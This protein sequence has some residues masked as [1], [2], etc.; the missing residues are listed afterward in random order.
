MPG[1]N[2]APLLVLSLSPLS[3]VAA[4]APAAAAATT[5]TEVS[6]AEQISPF[7]L[8][9]IDIFGQFF[10]LLLVGPHLQH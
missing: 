9:N 6:Q 4:T 7:S 1:L 10:L 5:T 3:L 8:P 2:S